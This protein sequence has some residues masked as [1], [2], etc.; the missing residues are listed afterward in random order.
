MRGARARSAAA[1][2]LLCGAFACE[3]VVH[4]QASNDVIVAARAAF[5]KKDRD[6]LA[7]ARA[8]AAASQHPLAMWVDYWELNNRLSEVSQPEVDAFY[9][10]WRNTYVE[11]RLRNDWLLELGLRRDWANFAV[12]FPR[13]RMNDDREVTCY[14]LLV[15]HMNGKEVRDTARAAW[16]AQKDS[17]D[18]C[19][20]LAATLVDA[21]VFN[22]ADVWRKTRLAIDASRPRAARQAAALVSL[23]A[24]SLVQEL[25]DSPPRFLSRNK[26]ARG[27]RVDAELATLALMR[28]A[29][30]DPD[31]AA[32]ALSD[33]WE[34]ALPND[35]ASWAWAATAKQ[36]AMKLLPDAADHYRHAARISARDDANTLDWPAETMAWKA[37]AALRADAGKGRWEQVLQ[38]IDAMA[39]SER[40]EAT[41][42]YW[43]ARALQALAPESAE[44]DAQ[45]AHARHLL[46]S[47]AGQLSFYGALASEALGQPF[48]LPSPPQPLTAEERAAAAANSGLTRGLLLAS[49]GLRD[50]GRR[51]W[52]YSLRGMSDRELLAAAAMAC[53]VR[54]WQL[55]IN[56]SE[57]TRSEI[58]L[59][60]R[61]PTPYRDEI[62]QR[63]RELDLDPNYVLGLIRQE[64]RFMP[65]LRSHAGASGLMQV[66]PTTAKWVARKTGLEYS[67]DMISDPQ[68]NLRLGTSYL[69]MVLDAFEGS[70]AMAA[71]AYN[72][73]PN[74][75][76]RWREGPW[77]ETA[78]WTENIPFPETRDYVKKVL[79][80]ASIYAALGNGEAPVLR[81]RLGRLIG[82]RD[83]NAP[84]PDKDLP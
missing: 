84:V 78:A 13:F 46:G 3:P 27:S 56:T 11:D 30:H 49:I 73:G 61:F 83:S 34:R 24:A 37:R 23:A 32:L 12:D 51:E 77:L 76:R 5:G 35:L 2:V 63:A 8:Q 41:W 16:F 14:A 71:A 50:E 18:G 80:N 53:D 70:Q 62:V 60:Q 25:V 43:R 54:D 17:D 21:R 48:A 1:L 44:G 40:R 19:N 45:R 20:L 58:D 26:P 55:C 66:M 75:P 15:E 36:S 65:T 67:P 64:T 52:N 69:K 59:S 28:M 9:A 22:P 10:R 68:T 42:V 82:P 6:R 74:R 39:P 31:A 79:S 29:S 38:A 72:A 33:R 4:A 47:I 7:L 57:R 81:P